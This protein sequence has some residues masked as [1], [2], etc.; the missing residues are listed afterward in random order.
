MWQYVN[1]NTSGVIDLRTMTG[2][3][4]AGVESYRSLPEGE[5]KI[6][7]IDENSGLN[8]TANWL[9]S[10]PINIS[11][12]ATPGTSVTRSSSAYGNA[13]MT[14][15]N[16]IMCEGGTLRVDYSASALVTFSSTKKPWIA[17]GKRLSGVNY[18]T[19]WAYTERNETSYK[20]FSPRSAYSSQ[21]GAGE[22]K[23]LKSGSYSLYYLFGDTIDTGYFYVEPIGINVAPSYTIGARVGGASIMN[24]ADPYNI[25]TV[26]ANVTVTDADVARGYIT[27]SFDLSSLPANSH[28]YFN[29]NNVSLT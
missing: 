27:V 20:A 1:D 18:Y 3:S 5:Y 16:N 6:Y 15:A 13:S 7:F 22:Y 26:S 17:M 19:H 4:Q 11:V 9:I 8:D 2:A 21:G 29:V 10:E 24:A 14:V 23:A 28:F 12:V 25:P